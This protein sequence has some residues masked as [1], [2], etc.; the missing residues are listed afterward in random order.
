M[1]KPLN[2]DWPIPDVRSV[3]EL[4]NIAVA[5]EA[6]AANRYGQ[7]ARRVES[8]GQAELAELFT[9]LAQLERDHQRG[10]EGWAGREGR[11]QPT[12]TQFSW[13]L[14]ETFGDD[15]DERPLDPY[16]ALAVAVRNEER[17]FA[18]YTYLA[19]LCAG[20]RELRTRAEAL[21][22]E[23]LKHVALLRGMRRRAFHNRAPRTP[24]ARIE[25]IDDLR[26][27]ARGLEAG[28]AQLG[29]LLAAALAGHPAA[30]LLARPAAE[31]GTLP[32]SSTVD[33]ARRDGRLA[34]G[35]LPTAQLLH[36]ALSDAQEVL[37]TYLS[38]A[39]STSQEDVLGEAQRLGEQAMARLALIRSLS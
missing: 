15:A 6:E 4:M 17:A 14:P 27:L 3:D 9:R 35:A 23:E 20:D 12:P 33:H 10:L 7:L 8:R 36:L 29:R 22:R 32:A 1:R 39:E 30:D 13:Q 37:D 11:S 19:A 16:L 28:S 21:A 31:A 25:T 5:M 24:T 34:P 26:R 2:P 18:F 38:I